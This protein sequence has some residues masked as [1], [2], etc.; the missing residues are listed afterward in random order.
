M[1]TKFELIQLSKPKCVKLQ[2]ID[3]D[4]FSFEAKVEM[5]QDRFDALWKYCEGNWNE[6]KYAEIEHEGFYENGEPINPI[7]KGIK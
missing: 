5:E 3:S 2:P 7:F 4:K 1:K 6:K